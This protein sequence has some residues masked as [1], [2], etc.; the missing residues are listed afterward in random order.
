MKQDRK[1]KKPPRP[2]TEDRLRHYAGRYL[3]RFTCSTAH[4]RRLM[5]QKCRDSARL[6]DIDTALTAQWIETVLAE[7]TSLGALDD[8]AYACGRAQSLLRKGKPVRFI[9]ADLA[10]RGLS[11][12]HIT[13][14]IGVLAE[15]HPDEHP[16]HRAAV[17]Y[18]KRR[19]FGPYRSK[20][21]TTETRQKERA[22]MMRAGF[23]YDLARSILEGSGVRDQESEV[24]ARASPTSD[25]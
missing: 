23:G 21:E 24:R 2:I 5:T 22:A 6:S 3:E 18:A 10:A 16:D 13:A 14:A 4:L 20:P 11:T 12:S 7:Y 1:P 9:R 15:D 17:A 8:G 25:P 19:R